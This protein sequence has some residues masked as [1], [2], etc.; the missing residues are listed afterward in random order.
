MSVV[1]VRRA[2][3]GAPATSPA[4]SMTSSRGVKVHYLGT[5]YS[6]RS[7]DRC[8]AYVRDIRASHLANKK[9]NYV[10]IAYNLL[11]C[12]HGYVYEGRGTRRRGGA[13]GSAQLNLDHFSVCALLGSSG[14]TQPTPAMIE[15]IRFA[16]A[17]FRAEGSA[18]REIRGHKD[19]YSTSCPG[20]AL[21]ALVTSGALEPG[22]TGDGTPAPNLPSWDGTS[23]PGAQAFVLGKSHPAVTLLGQRL[24][25]HGHGGF[26]K[27]GPG[28]TFGEADRQATAAFQRAQG[29]SGSDADG[30]PG[31][32]TWARL[33]AAPA[34]TPAPAPA[35]APP[36]VPVVSL[37]AVINS[38]KADPPKAGV[39]TSNYTDVIVVEHALAAEGLLDR[40]RADGHF[41]SDT[42]A[43]YAAFQRRLGYSGAD[44]DGIPGQTSLSKLGAR[45]GFRVTA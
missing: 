44:A 35:P 8:A 1:Y 40:A 15:G 4:A 21:Y 25:A 32:S 12:E 34:S 38:A 7:H 11:V 28:P 18:G 2:E 20:P 33:M 31:P 23:F 27:E 29:W 14:L 9:E 6:S 17:L 19:G 22:S 16:I 30:Y 13:N 41:G 36:P 24:V 26:Y 42:V 10:D 3:W 43:A 39:P 5:P 37:R 45:R